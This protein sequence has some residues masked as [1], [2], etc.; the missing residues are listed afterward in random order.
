MRATMLLA[1]AHAELAMG[2]SAL[3]LA[4]EMRAWFSARASDDWELALMHAIDAHAAHAAG[5]SAA[6]AE[7]HRHAAAALAAIANDEDRAIVAETLRRVPA[8]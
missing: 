7:A 8:P 3:A 5:L 6:H 1:A 4:R 2:A